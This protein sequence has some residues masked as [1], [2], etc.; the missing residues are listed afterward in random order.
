MKVEGDHLDATVALLIQIR[1]LLDAQGRRVLPDMQPTP[2]S[3]DDSGYNLV[4]PAVQGQRIFV[5][6][7]VIV[8]AGAVTFTWGMSDGTGFHEFA[9]TNTAAA[10]RAGSMSLAANGGVAH[11][12]RYPQFVLR[13]EPGMGLACNLSSGVQVGGELVYWVA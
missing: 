6:S 4:V 10:S 1:D 7:Y 5:A 9:G 3:V 8:A 2:F 13:C 12:S 11:V